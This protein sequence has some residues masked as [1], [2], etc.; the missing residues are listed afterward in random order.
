MNRLSLFVHSTIVE[1]L[2]KTCICQTVRFRLW[3]VDKVDSSLKWFFTGFFFGKIRWRWF[4]QQTSPT[5]SGIDQPFST[6]NSV[7]FIR[8]EH[9]S[10]DFIKSEPMRRGEYAA[11][12]TSANFIPNIQKKNQ[13]HQIVTQVNG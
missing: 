5:S 10:T 4:T 11:L 1:L 6:C 9:L 3:N 13:M 8:N 12:P 2:K 7:Q